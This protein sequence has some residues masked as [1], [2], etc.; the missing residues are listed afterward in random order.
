M[1]NITTRPIAHQYCEGQMKSTLHR[2]FKVHE[3]SSL[4]TGEYSVSR[5]ALVVFLRQH[6][7][8]G[9]QGVSLT[10]PGVPQA[11]QAYV[12]FMPIHCFA[13]PS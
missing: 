5:G 13:T 9:Y 8:L 7:I 10:E 11:A 1:L 2:E 4:A 3:A 6:E 12:C